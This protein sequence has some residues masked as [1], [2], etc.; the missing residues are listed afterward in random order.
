[1]AATENKKESGFLKI[2]ILITAISIAGNIILFLKRNEA[3]PKKRELIAENSRLVSQVYEY[4]ADLNKYKGISKKIDDVIKDA[5]V[6]IEEKEKQINKL[7]REK[8]LR[9]KENQKLTYEL[10]SLREQYIEVIDSL[11]VERER[12]KVINNKIENLEQII[13]Q[14]NKKIGVA[15]YLVGYNIN[16]IP[17]KVSR[18]GAKRATAIARKID[19]LEVCLDILENKLAGSGEKELYFLLTA[20]DGE[21]LVDGGGDPKTFYYSDLKKE[22]KCS[23]IGVVD[24]NKET[25]NYCITIK[26]G[27]NLRPGL[28]VLEIYTSENQLGTTTFTLN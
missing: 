7:I 24:Y 16:V 15:S 5:S 11:L 13:A 21:I 6:R 1:M 4:K 26:P 17:K 18:S 27:I 2:L 28:Y 23:K 14:L 22:G 3:F 19:E 9:E 25:L 8:K 10:D 12:K 20:P